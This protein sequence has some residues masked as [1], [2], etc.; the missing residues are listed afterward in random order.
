MACNS[1][2]FKREVRERGPQR[3]DLG[4]VPDDYVVALAG[5]PNT[6]KSTVFNS[7]TGLR[8]HT[9]NWPGKTVSRAEGTFSYAGK[10][11]KLVDLP[12][13]YS[14]LADS[15]DEQIA[16][17]FVL[18]GRPDCT[19][20]VCDATVLERNLH[21]VLQVLEITERVVVC[22][23]LMDEADRKRIALEARVLERE[24]GV[25]VVPTAARRGQGLDHLAEHVHEVAAGHP[26]TRPVRV[27]L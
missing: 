6:G 10:R 9:G 8:Q 1:C 26:R 11:F 4:G 25:P 19:V 20:V 2:A 5:N 16:R 18:F 21:L 27:G 24:L 22:A 23:N 15:V 13:T 14:L 12:G 17:D 3:V 7:L